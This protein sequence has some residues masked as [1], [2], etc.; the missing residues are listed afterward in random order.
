MWIYDRKISFSLQQ[1]HMSVIKSLIRENETGFITRNRP[2]IGKL[3]KHAST[4][5]EKETIVIVT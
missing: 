1:N 3:I 5:L 4:I 2:Y